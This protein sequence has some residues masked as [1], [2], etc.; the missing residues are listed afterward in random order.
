M[1][2]VICSLSICWISTVLMVSSLQLFYEDVSLV[3]VTVFAVYTLGISAVSSI[4][5]ILSIN[6]FYRMYYLIIKASFRQDY[7][8]DF[9]KIKSGGLNEYDPEDE[10]ELQ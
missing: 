7:G 8:S 10:V 5:S 2:L 9:Q 1:M 6:R 3:T 4:L